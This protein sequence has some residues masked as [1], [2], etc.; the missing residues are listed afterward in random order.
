MR[1]RRL[2]SSLV[3][4]S[5]LSFASGYVKPIL[6][7]VLSSPRQKKILLHSTIQRVETIKPHKLSY[8]ELKREL[9]SLEIDTNNLDTKTMQDMLASSARTTTTTETA[10]DSSATT[11][12]ASS[13]PANTKTTIIGDVSFRWDRS[14]ESGGS[15]PMTSSACITACQEGNWKKGLRK[16]KQ[17]KSA[18][19]RESGDEGKVSEEVYNAI[20]RS[21]ARAH[22]QGG[23]A[24]EPARKVGKGKRP[25]WFLTPS[26]IDRG[27]K[28]FD[29]SPN[30]ITIADY[31]GNGFVQLRPLFHSR[32][33]D[34][35][36]L[37]WL[38]V[39]ESLNGQVVRKS[40]TAGCNSGGN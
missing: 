1:L 15:I 12:T 40:R 33:H 3:L 5:L 19:A 39:H 35:D 30:F 24:G 4:L 11:A 13:T 28:R 31:R 6:T 34:S 37:A 2:Q 10:A 14:P 8:R 21:L 27:F 25:W 23:R 36:R 9:A 20:L 32:E 18:I 17:L 7:R 29:Y 16:L 38:I 22:L 26:L